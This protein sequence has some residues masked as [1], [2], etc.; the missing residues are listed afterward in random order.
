MDQEYYLNIKKIIEEN[1]LRKT[2]PGLEV[3]FSYQNRVIIHQTFG[4]ESKEKNASVLKRN[5][6]FDI[7]SL[8]KPYVTSLAVLQL[9]EQKLIDLK[10]PFSK[11]LNHFKHSDKSTITILELLTHTSG[12][13]A[14]YPLFEDG[15]DLKIAQDKLLS[16]DIENTPGSK[17]VY[18]CLGYLILGELVRKVSSL[19]LSQ[20]CQEQIFSKLKQGFV[21]FKPHTKSP[22]HSLI[23]TA[24]CNFRKMQL[25]GVVHD[26]NAYLFQEE[27]GNA[28]VFA[29]IDGLTAL[30]EMIFNKGYHNGHQIISEH[31]FKIWT[32]N[33]NASTIDPRTVGWDINNSNATYKSCGDFM[34]D[35]AI[36]H[37]GFTG[38]SSWLYLPEKLAIIL[39]SNRINIDRDTNIQQMRLFRPQIHNLLLSYFKR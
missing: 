23:A 34:P 28:G 29:N 17:M 11:Y 6:I 35:G 2:F 19:S 1:I 27:G 24:Y 21:S 18:S 30:N 8:T 38:T 4:L 25:K 39:L 5:S 26:E 22:N 12:L 36:G 33:Q 15:F 32:S 37:L 13:P 16:M 10:L 3:Y 20:Y 7:A 31:Y 14:W 9:A